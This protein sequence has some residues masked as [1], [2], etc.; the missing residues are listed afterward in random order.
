M[1]FKGLWAD[2]IRVGGGIPRLKLNSNYH[3]DI[4]VTEGRMRF[5]LALK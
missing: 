2:I 4:V 5:S 3:P 1:N